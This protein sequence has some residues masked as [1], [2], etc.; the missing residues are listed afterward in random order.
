MKWLDGEQRNDGGRKRRKRE[1]ERK[2]EKNSFFS[3]F[4]FFCCYLLVLPTRTTMKTTKLLPR[5][6][7]ARHRSWTIYTS[8]SFIYSCHPNHFHL[9][10]YPILFMGITFVS[11]TVEVIRNHLHTFLV[12]QFKEAKAKN[13]RMKKK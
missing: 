10:I 9:S 1:Q 11:V 6:T 8:S 4:F 5:P 3:S 7:T 13:K 12:G 2:E